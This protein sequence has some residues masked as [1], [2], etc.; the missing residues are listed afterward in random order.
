MEVVE[1]TVQVTLSDGT[2]LQAKVLLA[3]EVAYYLYRLFDGFKKIILQ[4]E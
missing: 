3:D 4:M 2:K 1:G